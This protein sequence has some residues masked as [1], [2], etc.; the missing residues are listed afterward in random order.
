MPTAAPKDRVGDLFLCLLPQDWDSACTVT[1]GTRQRLDRAASHARLRSTVGTP[2]LD[3]ARHA[4]AAP[5]APSA[6]HP[7][8]CAARCR[9][10]DPGS[11]S[12]VDRMGSCTAHPRESCGMRDEAKAVEPGEVTRLVA[13]QFNAGDAAVC[14]GILRAAGTAG[15]PGRRRTAAR[16]E[17]CR[18]ARRT[19]ARSAAWVA[20]RRGLRCRWPPTRPRSVSGSGIRAGCGCAQRA[21]RRSVRRCQVAVRFPCSSGPR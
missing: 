16:N 17:G 18:S 20:G 2:G 8:G 15:L 5:T 4:L 3:R 21:L 7:A 10:S 9:H 13:E 6:E 11:A 14:G 1:A 19:R 12:R